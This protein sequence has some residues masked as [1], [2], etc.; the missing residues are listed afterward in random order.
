[1][2]SLKSESSGAPDMF[3]APDSPVRQTR[4]AFG[5]PLALLSNHYLVFLLAKCE[6]LAPV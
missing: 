2:T 6:P 4:G 5:Y 1:V 3:G